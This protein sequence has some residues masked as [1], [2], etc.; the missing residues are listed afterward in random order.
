MQEYLNR[1][2]EPVDYAELAE[3]RKRKHNIII[4]GFW[5]KSDDQKEIVLKLE[6]LFQDAYKMHFPITNVTKLNNALFLVRLAYLRDKVHILKNKIR[7]FRGE[8]MFNPVT[9]YSDLT[10]D[11]KKITHRISQRAKAEKKKGNLVKVGYMRLYINN[12]RWVWSPAK[13]DLV[14]R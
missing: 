7:L 3:R 9:V 5:I 10:A 14:P 11:E 4:Q 2:D 8:Y 6:Q 13:N 1:P 12:R